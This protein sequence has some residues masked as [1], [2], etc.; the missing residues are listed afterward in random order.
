MKTRSPKPRS[1]ARR[2]T[3]PACRGTQ[4]GRTRK[5]QEPAKPKPRRREIPW[6]M[7]LAWLLAA[8]LFGILAAASCTHAHAATSA[9]IDATCRVSTPDGGRGSGCVFEIGQGYV[10]VIT[11]AHVVGSYSEVS[12]EFWREGHQSTPIPGQVILRATEQDADAAIVALRQSQFGGLL[13][14]VVPLAPRTWAVQPGQTL[15]SSGCAR[16]AWSTSWKGH[17]LGYR[18]S[19]LYFTPAPAQGRSGSALF[20][21]EGRQIVGIV[22]A[23]TAD[24]Q[25]GIA[26]SL[27][28]LYAGLG[29]AA[30]ARQVQCGPDGCVPPYRA[31][32]YRQKQE[33]QQWRQQESERWPTMPPAASPP[34]DLGPVTARLDAITAQMQRDQQQAAKKEEQSPSAAIIAVLVVAA[35][36]IGGVGFF[37]TQSHTG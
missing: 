35:L 27:Q 16:G 4:N 5:R 12:C 25:A 26:C 2:S 15:L 28:A 32:P 23:R 21:A 29:A 1:A 3:S 31:L 13:P 7:F 11:A 17:A 37:S 34:V 19:D 18:G 24:D 30:A 9:Y 20:D 10:Y 8:V 14:T 33:F 22:R 36:V 6:A